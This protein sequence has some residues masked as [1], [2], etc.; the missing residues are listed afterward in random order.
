MVNIQY[1]PNLSVG[2]NLKIAIVNACAN[3]II[4]VVVGIIE[5]CIDKAN[6]DMEEYIHN[7]HNNTLLGNTTDSNQA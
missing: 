5:K 1:N 6:G 4:S 3:F 2:E 7:H